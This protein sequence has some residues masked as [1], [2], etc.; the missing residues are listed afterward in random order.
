MVRVC[1]T[2]QNILQ[3]HFTARVGGT[4]WPATLSNLMVPSLLPLWVFQVQCVC[5]SF[6][7]N[8]R[9]KNWIVEEVRRITGD[10]LQIMQEL[11][12]KKQSLKCNEVWNNITNQVHFIH[13][14]RLFIYIQ[15]CFGSLAIIRDNT[16]HGK[17]LKTIM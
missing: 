3:G 2:R 11:K 1:M 16:N 15:T 10:L 5:K 8:H 4:A 7:N 17:I 6:T 14:H 12:V 13:I 9:I